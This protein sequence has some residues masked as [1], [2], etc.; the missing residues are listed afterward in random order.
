M[1]SDCLGFLTAKVIVPSVMQDSKT[2]KLTWYYNKWLYRFCI[3]TNKQHRFTLEVS[4]WTKLLDKVNIC[5][6]IV[7]ANVLPRDWKRLITDGPRTLTS[8]V[9]DHICQ[10][11]VQFR[12][13]N[14][15][16]LF[17]T[18]VIY[19]IFEPLYIHYIRDLSNLRA[20]VTVSNWVNKPSCLKKQFAFQIWEL[21]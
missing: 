6:H 10:Y 14:L 21:H 20:S 11:K 19:L 3:V 17:L 8:S 13:R 2:C 12:Y 16:F 18:C 1:G 7:L 4:P 9:R 15:H 5:C